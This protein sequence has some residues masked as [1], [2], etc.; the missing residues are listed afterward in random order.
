[1]KK[2]NLLFGFALCL[3][4]INQST[5]TAQNLDHV[6]NEALVQLKADTDVKQLEKDLKRIDGVATQLR[7]IRK[8]SKQLNIYKLQFDHIAIIF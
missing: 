6:L 5:L 1:M 4:L 7:I 3:L 8:I 2:F